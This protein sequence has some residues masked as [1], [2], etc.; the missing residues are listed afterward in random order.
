MIDRGIFIDRL[1]AAKAN[2]DT[3]AAHAQA[4]AVLCSLLIVLGYEDVIEAWRVV[5]KWYA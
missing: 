5:D 1:K 3:E 2:D 4:D